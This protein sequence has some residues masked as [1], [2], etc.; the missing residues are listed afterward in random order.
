[1]NSCIK[2]MIAVIFLLSLS[3]TVASQIK[4]NVKKKVVT[5]TNNQAKEDKL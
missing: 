4:V 1:M 2:M 5:Q 3:M